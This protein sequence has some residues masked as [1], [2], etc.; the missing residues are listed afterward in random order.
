[1]AQYATHKTGAAGKAQTL[2]GRGRMSPRDYR[3]PFTLTGSQW[4]A[5]DRLTAAYA[6]GIEGGVTR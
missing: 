4:D 1:M 6:A 3:P 5:F 2:R